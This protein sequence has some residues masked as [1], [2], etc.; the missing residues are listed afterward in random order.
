MYLLF[1][2]LQAVYHEIRHLDRYVKR[3]MN[4]KVQATLDLVGKIL[5]N[6]NEITEK[7][8]KVLT[9]TLFTK[10]DVTKSIPF[11]TNHQVEEFF[12]H[13]EN[14]EALAHYLLLNTSRDNHMAHLS[15][16]LCFHITYLATH[17]WKFS[18]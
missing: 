16:N 13:E 7:M 8:D 11:H 6:Q 9:K 2:D 5:D 3:T 1:S 10:V 4:D 12:Q 17:Y 15:M 14:K 18:Q